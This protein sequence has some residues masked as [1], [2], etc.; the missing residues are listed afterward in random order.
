M[1][2]RL[3][4]PSCEYK[5]IVSVRY[6]TDTGTATCPQQ[7]CKRKFKYRGPDAPLEKESNPFEDLFGKS[8]SFGDL[9]KGFKK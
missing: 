1:K 8:N 3:K 4:C 5:F 6:S 2:F 7:K 9:F